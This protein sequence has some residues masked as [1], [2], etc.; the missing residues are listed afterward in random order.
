MLGHGGNQVEGTTCRPHQRLRNFACLHPLQR[1]KLLG[2]RRPEGRSLSTYEQ[3]M[4]VDC[5]WCAVSPVWVAGD[6]A[7]C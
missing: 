5:L 1:S 2:S 7:R 4:V 3:W 6:T